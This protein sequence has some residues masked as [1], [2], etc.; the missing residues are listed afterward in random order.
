MIH[1]SQEFTHL[2]VMRIDCNL[3]WINVQIVICCCVAEKME[4]AGWCCKR[5]KDTLIK[6]RNYNPKT[7]TISPWSWKSERLIYKGTWSQSSRIHVRGG[8]LG[9]ESAEQLKCWRFTKYCRMAKNWKKLN[10]KSTAKDKVKVLHT[11]VKV[12][13]D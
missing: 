9:Y 10:S 4:L 7:N 3:N 2:E 5:L 12:L 13:Q 11:K 6:C 1:L 8:L